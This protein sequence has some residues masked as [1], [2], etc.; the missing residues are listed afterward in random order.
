MV[1]FWPKIHYW[2]YYMIV[3]AW[4]IYQVVKAN[5]ACFFF[6]NLLKNFLFG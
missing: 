6:E 3:N 2:N 4:L 1:Q 5:L